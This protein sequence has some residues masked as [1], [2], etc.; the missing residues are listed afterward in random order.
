[1]YF[2]CRKGCENLYDMTPETYKV[3]KDAAGLK[4]VTQEIDELDKNH[5]ADSSEVANTAKMYETH[6]KSQLN[7]EK[8]P[9]LDMFC[10]QYG[11]RKCSKFKNPYVSLSTMN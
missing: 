11:G 7:T 3:Y 9:N 8:S 2:T 6:G 1:M 5:Q 4:Y 10:S